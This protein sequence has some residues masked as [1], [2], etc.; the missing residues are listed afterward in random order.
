M[1][2]ACDSTN[3]AMF[4]RTSDRGEPAKINLCS[5]R[6]DAVE[7]SPDSSSSGPPG[8]GTSARGRIALFIKRPFLPPLDSAAWPLD[9][10]WQKMQETK[11]KLDDFLLFLSKG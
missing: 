6:T 11:D 2:L 8:E 7:N 5:L 9:L 10:T 1:P 3:C 4:V